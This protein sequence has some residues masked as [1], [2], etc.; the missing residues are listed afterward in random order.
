MCEGGTGHGTE[1]VV[2]R[3]SAESTTIT[4][5][6]MD[7]NLNSTDIQI[8]DGFRLDLTNSA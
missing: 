5:M 1:R 7:L 2:Q 3:T 8:C 6:N 4:E